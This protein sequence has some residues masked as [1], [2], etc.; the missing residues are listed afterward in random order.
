M[1]TAT[2][3]GRVKY[4][5]LP[6]VFFK[7]DRRH[8]IP[9]GYEYEVH[10]HEANFPTNF[11]YGFV[12]AYESLGGAM[13]WEIKSPVAPLYYHKYLLKKLPQIPWNRHPNGTKNQGGIHINIEKTDNPPES[14]DS[15]YK[16]LQENEQHI[17]K[18]SYRS[19]NTFKTF[20][21]LTDF[22]KYNPTGQYTLV[23]DDPSHY[24][25]ILSSRKPNCYEFR[26]FAALPHL[27][28]PALEMADSMFM[29]VREQD[30]TWDSWTNYIKRWPRY[31]NIWGH[32]KE[33]LC[34]S[35]SPPI[36]AT[37]TKTP[38]SS[39]STQVAA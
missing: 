38:Q 14:R 21:K 26:M 29:L 34:N 8:G 4:S 13:G 32:V 24:Y 19:S 10:C 16:F 31:R 6:L 18:L 39:V 15:I 7:S 33:T 5:A 27:L 22:A 28:M 20:A 2:E 35:S 12:T 3:S 37:T 17:F 36:S 30:I 9:L 11:P 23:S 25:N 1:I